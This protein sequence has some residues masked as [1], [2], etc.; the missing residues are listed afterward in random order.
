MK[1]WMAQIFGGFLSSKIGKLLLKYT[2]FQSFAFWISSYFTWVAKIREAAD[3]NVEAVVAEVKAERIIN[4]QENLISDGERREKMLKRRPRLRR[5]LLFRDYCLDQARLLYSRLLT[6][7]V[8]GSFLKIYSEYAE[9]EEARRRQFEASLDLAGFEATS[10]YYEGV[11]AYES[12]L[13]PF[14][15]VCFFWTFWSSFWWQWY[16]YKSLEVHQQSWIYWKVETVLYRYFVLIWYRYALLVKTNVWYANALLIPVYYLAFLVGGIVDLASVLSPISLHSILAR[17]FIKAFVET[18]DVAIRK[19]IFT[20]LTPE[21]L[22]LNRRLYE[23][24]TA[25]IEKLIVEHRKRSKRQFLYGP[26]NLFYYFATT[27]FKLCAYVVFL[28]FPDY[29]KS[30]SVLWAL[31]Q[32]DFLN[33]RQLDY[34]LTPG[35]RVDIGAVFVVADLWLSV[36]M[37]YAEGGDAESLHSAFVQEVW[38]LR[39][40]Y[41]VRLARLRSIIPGIIKVLQSFWVMQLLRR[42]FNI[43]LF[44]FKFYL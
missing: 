20:Y 11:A 6:M 43:V 22:R 35:R 10:A 30:R 13:L 2:I 7:P 14:A 9:R 3:K 21:E 39:H 23:F 36:F 42:Y 19:R 12:T 33:L 32:T 24:K 16:T 25:W 37:E 15:L 5:L 17:G 1:A 29:V 38:D 34:S 44:I 40:I 31:L 27:I 41:F 4:D 26:T 18:P 8:L 28:P